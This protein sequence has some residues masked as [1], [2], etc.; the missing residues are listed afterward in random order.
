MNAPAPAPPA[1]HWRSV[2]WR[3]L[4]LGWWLQRQAPQ[5]RLVLTHRNIYILPTRAGLMLGVTLLLLLVGSIN[6]QLNLGYLLT[7]M[8]AG[9]AMVAL[10]LTH[11]NLRGL[12]LTALPHHA[13]FAG[14]ASHIRLRV[15]N[16]TRRAR[17]GL[18]LSWRQHGDRRHPSPGSAA[19]QND[20]EATWTD[21]PP[22]AS[23]AVEVQL[24]FASRGLHPMPPVLIQTRFP[25][26][27]S[28]AWHWWRPSQQCLVYPTPEPAPPPLPLGASGEDDAPAL[29]PRALG[30]AVDMDGV[31][32]Y[33]RGDPL[34][35]VLWKKV[36]RSAEGMT[37]QWVSRDATPP[38]AGQLWLDMAATGLSN[39]EASLSRLCAWVLAADNAGLDY[40]LRL[41][42]TEI[43]PAHG[44][45]HRR[46][47]LEALACA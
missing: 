34:K 17:Y 3:E 13:V 21:A 28:R 40:G 6:Y 42:G 44:D 7:F 47:C 32:P 18:G 33:R 16:P 36:A 22:Q 39:T 5:D 15:N 19:N 30:A 1:R 12:E 14:Q 23:R 29:T 2:D 24:T 31:R 26:G 41:P 45:A 4:G 35:W 38:A 37:P 43:P 10:H 27:T 20:A 8:L 46:R 11:L 9:C 25:L